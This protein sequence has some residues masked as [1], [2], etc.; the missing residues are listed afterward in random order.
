MPPRTLWHLGLI[1]PAA[2]AAYLDW[3][4][5]SGRG[6][7]AVFESWLERVS[8][9]ERPAATGLELDLIAAVIDVG[10]PEPVRQHAVTLLDGVTIHID[11]AWPDLR[12]GLEPGHS[13]WHAGE[14]DVQ[15]DESRFRRCNEVGW[16]I[17]P[18]NE[19]MLADLP[20]VAMQIKR[21]YE[22]RRTPP[23]AS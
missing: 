10:L 15:R 5:R 2:A 12:L 14:L 4:R 22:T 19:A 13:L 17:V 7:V 16:L 23:A 8:G 9:W 11:I 20:S 1:D 21:I 6:G 3:I 18:L